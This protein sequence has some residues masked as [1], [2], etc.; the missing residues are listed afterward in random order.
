MEK[1]NPEKILCLCA[2]DGLKDT[3]EHRGT[4]KIGKLLSVTNYDDA[5]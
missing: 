3:T 1:L 2:S 4:E 5:E